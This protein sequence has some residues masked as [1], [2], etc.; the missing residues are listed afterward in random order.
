[1]YVIDRRRNPQGRSLGNRQR[2]IRRAREQIRE[3]LKD[4]LRQRSIEDV[5]SGEEVVISS[6][7]I[8]EPR[9]TRDSRQSGC[10][11]CAHFT[12]FDPMNPAPPVTKTLVRLTI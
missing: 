10:A 8:H 12:K 7:G 3:A 11:A 1:M 9:F 6:D 4:K 5:G 2:F